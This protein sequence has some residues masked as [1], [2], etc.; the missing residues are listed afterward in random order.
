MGLVS[1]KEIA[2][3][4]NL[5]K[6]GFFGTF[7]GWLL[8][9][10]LRIS[11]I[12]R[13][14]EKHKDKKNVA[15]L[16]AIL[17]E[18]QIDFEIPEED[19]KRIPNKGSFITVSNHPLGGIDGILLLK[20][21]VEQRPD[22]KIIA[23]FLL[24]RIEPLKPYVMPVN[25]FEDRKEVQSSLRGIKNALL[26]LRDGHSLG[27]FPA[28]EVSTYKDGK[29]IVDKPWEEGAVK[30]IHKAKVPVIPIYFH[31]KN[32]R[33][34]YLLS[35]ISDTFRTAKLPSEVL[36][37]KSR[38]IK[39]RIGKPISVKAQEEYENID[40]FHT[41]LRKKTYMLANPFEVKNPILKKPSLKIPKQPKKVIPPVSP[42]KINKEV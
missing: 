34:F 1:S 17:N 5:E 10:I 30:L 38:I 37:Q 24:H 25:P 40:D 14:Y 6:Y 35:K 19:L 13:I 16:N 2:S 21:L 11:K 39:V 29:L 36:S 4:I 12:N 20:L 15:F 3:V 8:L 31:A 22:Y 27:I 26:H 28:G 32:S 41:F 7:I 23:N 9:K 33:L 42:T 18:V